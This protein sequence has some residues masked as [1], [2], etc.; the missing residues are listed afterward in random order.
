MLFLRVA[1]AAEVVVVAAVAIAVAAIIVINGHL[2]SHHLLTEPTGTLPPTA[3]H[4]T[5]LWQVLGRCYIITLA[6]HESPLT[7]VSMASLGR[8][9]PGPVAT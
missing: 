1:A 3:E 4:G 6:G 9:N 8:S 2:P 7:P 5:V